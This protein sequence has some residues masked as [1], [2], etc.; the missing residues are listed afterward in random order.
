MRYQHIFLLL[1]LLTILSIACEK[2]VNITPSYEGNKLVVNTMMQQDSPI[3]VRVTRSVPVNV[4]DE[5]AFEE[6]PSV[7]ISLTDE[8]GTVLPLQRQQILG[9]WYYVSSAAAVRG[10][11]YKV[12][13]SATG[14]VGVEASDTL[15]QKPQ[16]WDATAQKGSSRIKFILKDNPGTHDYYQLRVYNIDT[17]NRPISAL[18]FKL[19]PAFNNNLMDILSTAQRSILIMND[20]RF[21]GR[22]VTFV[23]QTQDLVPTTGKLMV[24]VTALTYNAYQ[25]LKTATEQSESYGD[26]VSEPVR[27]FTNV[28]NGY[29]IVAGINSNKLVFKVD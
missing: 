8:S 2:P 13:A 27:V 16:A 15:P 19:D 1:V 14:L 23:L 24:E 26:I 20:N 28:I 22:E 21:D 17:A 6:L 4:Y 18:Y 11:R 29:G 12:A 5:S 7:N 3:Y 10:H 9:K 25:Y